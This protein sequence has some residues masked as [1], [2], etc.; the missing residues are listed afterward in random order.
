MKVSLAAQTLSSSVADALDF[1]R[2]DLKLPDF[3]SS[4]ATSEFV[5]VFDS[6]F[7]CFNSRSPHGKRFKAPLKEENYHE[8]IS[9][10][11]EASIYIRSLKKEDGTPILFSR[12]RTGYLG[13]VCAISSFQNLYED[14]VVSR[15]LNFI[16][17]YK[18]SQVG[19]N[20]SANIFVILQLLLFYKD[21]FCT[22]T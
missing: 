11:A 16:L 3:K 18:F 9:L 14:L 10:F 15:R 7:D 19:Q 12:S 13:F 2:E 6:L 22:Q 20:F 8:W 17:G 21:F 1:L 4:K 5:R